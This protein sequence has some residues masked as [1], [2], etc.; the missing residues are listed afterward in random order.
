MYIASNT[1]K[2]LTSFRTPF[3]AFPK[4]WQ[5]SVLFLF[6]WTQS[7]A[8]HTR[9]RYFGRRE[10]KWLRWRGKW[11]KRWEGVAMSLFLFLSV[12]RLSSPCDWTACVC[13]PCCF[14]VFDQHEDSQEVHST[15]ESDYRS[16]ES[17]RQ[18]MC[19]STH[20]ERHKH[21]VKGSQSTNR[22]LNSQ[23]CTD[24]SE[25]QRHEAHE[26]IRRVS[27]QLGERVPFLS[28]FFLLQNIF[29]SALIDSFISE[30]PLR[31]IALHITLKL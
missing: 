27:S 30:P 25:S 8:C 2:V 21:I 19:V 7:C 1:H 16:R 12:S 9:N 3:A 26:L 14:T 17:V 24:C 18:G 29:P 20:G 31:C 13:L 10:T 5:N 23:L 15:K 11:E 4:P 6:L 28:S 22:R